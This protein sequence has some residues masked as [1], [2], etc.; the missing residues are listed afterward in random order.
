LSR[1]AISQDGTGRQGNF[2]HAR[3]LRILA[4]RSRARGPDKR[5]PPHPSFGVANIAAMMTD[6]WF[7]RKVAANQPRIDPGLTHSRYVNMSAA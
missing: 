5:S 6:A 1:L 7:E 2:R 4:Q 3:H